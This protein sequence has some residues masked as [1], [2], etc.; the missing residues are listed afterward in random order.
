MIK[1]FC[2]KCGTE[3]LQASDKY[4]KR[5]CNDD[6]VLKTYLLCYKCNK[7]FWEY[8]CLFTKKEEAEYGI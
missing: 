1:Y 8:I 4:I 7:A 3:L 6:H 2:D 5:V